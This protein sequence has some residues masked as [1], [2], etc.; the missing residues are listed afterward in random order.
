METRIKK[1]KYRYLYPAIMRIKNGTM[2]NRNKDKT[3]LPAN[4][5]QFFIMG[6][7]RNGSTLLA[8]MLNRH[9]DIFLPPEQ[10]ALPY[11]IMQ[12]H[13]KLTRDWASFCKIA[14]QAL[15][16]KNQHWTL[17][18]QDY[19][20]VEE[21]ATSLG[22]KFRKPE[23]L[24]TELLNYYASKF[25]KQI[26]YCGD[27]SPITTQFYKLLPAEF[28]EARFIFLVRH[29]LDVVLSYQKMKG[30]PASKPEYACWKW[31]DSIRALEWL[32]KNHHDKVL[33]IKYETLVANPEMI[34]QQLLA[35]LN[36]SHL[37]LNQPTDQENIT[38]PLG[39]KSHSHHENLYKPISQN[40]VNKWKSH[41]SPEIIK[42]TKPLV[43]KRARQFG[44]TF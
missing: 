1:I 33:V 14:L 8:L 41:L 42:N 32:K 34:S 36:L 44:Y 38:D 35:F 17:T 16:H 15:Q 39:A 19:R 18:E 10:Y 40:S 29:P 13:M 30:H 20:I 25:N 27:H 28:N 23:N 5:H 3:T 43:E 22:R 21:H 4:P 37:N 11:I 31:N 9:P 24:F 26:K 6:S 12:W 7:G 2:G